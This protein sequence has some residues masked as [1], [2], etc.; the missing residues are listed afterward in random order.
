MA[1]LKVESMYGSKVLSYLLWKYE[2]S[3]QS[4]GYKVGNTKIA[5]QQIEHISPQNPS[6]GDTIASGYETDENRRYSQDFRNEYLHCLG[7]LVLIS[8]THNRIIGNKPFKDKVASYNEN[9]VLK[10]QSEIKKFTNPDYPERWDKEAIDRRHIRIV[11]E[12]ALQKWNFEQVEIFE[13][14]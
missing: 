5:E 1:L 4:M 6:N 2:D 13:T 14:I 12:F 11:D 7:N 3:I 8:G 9:P 10:Q